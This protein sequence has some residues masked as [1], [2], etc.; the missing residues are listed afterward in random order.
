MQQSDKAL[1][2]ALRTLAKAMNDMPGGY[3]RNTAERLEAAAD[4][5]GIL[6]QGAAEDD[7]IVQLQRERHDILHLWYK[8][9]EACA[10]CAHK[11]TNVEAESCGECEREC[12]CLVCEGENWEEA[13]D[14]G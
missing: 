12:L 8:G 9:R 13:R 4:R 3:G 11:C 1:I 14:D 5:L 10:V 2:Q 6:A 7:R